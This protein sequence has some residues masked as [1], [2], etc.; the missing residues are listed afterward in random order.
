MSLQVQPTLNVGVPSNGIL[1]F[2]V[3]QGLEAKEI[4]YINL[5][6]HYPYP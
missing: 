3:A 5:L 2:Q 4:N 1:L 6:G